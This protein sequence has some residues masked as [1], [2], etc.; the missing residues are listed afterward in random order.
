MMLIGYGKDLACAVICRIHEEIRAV[1]PAVMVAQIVAGGAGTLH[2]R[3]CAPP[4]PPHRFAGIC[5]IGLLDMQRDLILAGKH[6]LM[7][8]FGCL[9]LG[10]TLVC[11]R[12]LL[13][14]LRRRQCLRPQAGLVPLCTGVQRVDIYR[15]LNASRLTLSGQAALHRHSL[16]RQQRQ[17]HHQCQCQCRQALSY[18]FHGSPPHV[19]TLPSP[20]AFCL[21]PQF[22]MCSRKST[23]LFPCFAA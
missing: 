20:G 21:R 7:Q 9:R 3:H 22:T 8:L 13:R 23:P 19:I 6:L 11:I 1:I 2:V 12:R 17:R 14:R 4:D 10:Q 5:A 15:C 18:P 16:Y